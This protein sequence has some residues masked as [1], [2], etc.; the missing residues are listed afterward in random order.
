MRC[1]RCSYELKENWKTCPKCSTIIEDNI[2]NTQQLEVIGVEQKQALPQSDGKDKIYLIV[3]VISVVLGFTI[4]KIRGIC[5]VVAL[6]TIVTAYIK[7]PKSRA[8]KILFWLF[9]VGIVVTI[10]SA[11]VLVTSVISSCG[12]S[13]R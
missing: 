11:I 2:D 1:K 4:E 7:Y 3:F 12:Y 10:I 6:I 13:C 8:I 9:L 5:F